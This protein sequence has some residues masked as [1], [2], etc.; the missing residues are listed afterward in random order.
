MR[1]NMRKLNDG[2]RAALIVK[3]GEGAASIGGLTC[4]RT[5]QLLEKWP[6]ILDQAASSLNSDAAC[7]RPLQPL[8]LAGQLLE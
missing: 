4:E 2:E 6:R 3:G 7:L 8:E 5:A 1:C